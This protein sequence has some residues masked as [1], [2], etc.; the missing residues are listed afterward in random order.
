VLKPQINLSSW[1]L[2]TLMSALAVA[3]TIRGSCALPAD[4]KWPND[5]IVNQRKM[6]G[7]LCE[8]VD[9]GTGYAVVVGIGINLYQNVFPTEVSHTA[10]SVEQETGIKP[11]LEVILSDL[12]KAIARRYAVLQTKGGTGQTIQ[13]WSANS[14]YA[15]GK[16]VRVESGTEVFTGVTNGLENDGALRVVLKT[17]ELKVVRAGDVQSLRGSEVGE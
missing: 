3:D 7:I 16:H 10:T 6:A 11:V 14:S 5:L 9:T 1:P 13:D 12:I 4:I 17:G 8:T 2:I 15:T